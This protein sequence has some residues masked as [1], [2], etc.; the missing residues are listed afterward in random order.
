MARFASF[1]TGVG[2]SSAD[3]TKV[4]SSSIT[5]RGERSTKSAV[6]YP[7]VARFEEGDVPV[8]QFRDRRVGG[9]RKA[10]GELN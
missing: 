2:Q 9:G 10:E 8:E 5:G 4:W 7:V 3:F 1:K 6:R